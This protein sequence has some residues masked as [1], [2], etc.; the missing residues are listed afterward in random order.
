MD[1]P[2]C[3]RPEAALRIH[4][5]QSIGLEPLSASSARE[6]LHL[7]IGLSIHIFRGSEGHRNNHEAQSSS[8]PALACRNAC[9][10]SAPPELHV[11]G[12]SRCGREGALPPLL[13]MKPAGR[14][15]IKVLAMRAALRSPSSGGDAV[16]VSWRT[17]HVST[18]QPDTTPALSESSTSAITNLAPS[19]GPPPPLQTVRCPASLVLPS[20][21][22]W[23]SPNAAA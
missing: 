18:P 20:T 6:Q 19:Q 12:T 13:E 17:L 2:P 21:G 8:F 14:F 11:G 16:R 23:K 1:G 15:L 7:V 4:Q 9:S 22:A 10:R 5:H 3:N